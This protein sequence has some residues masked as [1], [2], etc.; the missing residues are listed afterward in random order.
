MMV[1]RIAAVSDRGLS[2]EINEDAVHAGDNLIAVADGMGGLPAGEVASEIAIRSLAALEKESADASGKPIEVLRAAVERANRQIGEVVDA[3]P[4]LAGMGTT[5]TAM[6]LSGDRIALVHVGDSR[7]Y[8]F[9][10]GVLTQLTKDD[11]FVQSLVDKGAITAE[12]AR[13]HPQ[14]SL[15]TQAVQGRELSPLFVELKPRDGDRYL[16]CSDGLSDF[17]DE[18]AIAEALDRYA[19]PHKC[20]E[21]LIELALGAGGPDNVSAIVADAVVGPSAPQR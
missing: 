8:R 16:L 11:T 1:L 7:A 9:R 17:V 21:R 12:E 6:L 4:S 10:A 5:M 13:R 18:A 2:R 20:A 19:D 15:V 3:D 14:R